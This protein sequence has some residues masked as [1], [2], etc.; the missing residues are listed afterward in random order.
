[1]KHKLLLVTVFWLAA[2]VTVFAQPEIFSSEEG[3]IKGYDPVAFFKEHTPVKGKKENSFV[4]KEATWY[5]SSQENLKA[6]QSDPEKY[7]PQYGGYCAF[8]TAHG[9]KAPT[10]TDTWTIVE[11]KLYFNYNQDVKKDWTKDQKELIKK[12]DKNWVELKKGK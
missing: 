12:A 8:G 2:I 1:M 11:N 10:Q 3:A 4:W 5:F 6:F 7:A 9:H